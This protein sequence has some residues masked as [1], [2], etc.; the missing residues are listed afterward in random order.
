MWVK[1]I[2]LSPW[3]HIY[4]FKY[5]QSYGFSSSH[6]W[7]WELDHN[8]SWALKNW[9]FWTEELEKTLESPLD[10][11]EIK[12]V[13]PKRNQSLIFIGRTNTEAEAPIL[14]PPDAKN[15]PIGKDPDAGKDW[16]PEE[17]GMTED[18]MVGWHHQLEGYEFEQVLGAGYGQ[19][20]LAYCSAWGRKELDTTERWTEL[21]YIYL[22]IQLYVAQVISRAK[23]QKENK[24]NLSHQVI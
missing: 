7:M 22:H 20:S 10:Y 23:Q 12:S 18:E 8:E 19:G 24:G 17:K 9:C 15:W 6:I 21:K 13:C 16:R 4:S 3:I 14:W 2:C 1:H 5:S 11:K